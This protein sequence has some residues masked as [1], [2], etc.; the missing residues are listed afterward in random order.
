MNKHNSSLSLRL[1]AIFS[2]ILVLAFNTLAFADGAQNYQQKAGLSGKLVSTGSDTLANL[3]AYWVEDFQS[4]YPHVEFELHSEGSSTAPPALLNGISHIAPMSRLMSS[5]ELAQFQQKF[6]YPPTAVEVAIDAIAVFVHRD[7][8][9][10]AISVEQLAAIFSANSNC[11]GQQKISQWGQ[12]GLTDSWHSKPIEPYG[13]N[14]ESGSYSF[15]KQA[16][17]CNQDFATNM[18]NLPGSGSIV[19]A[20]SYNQHAIGFSGM[21]YKTSGVRTLPIVVNGSL[22]WPN[23]ENKAQWNYPLSRFLTLY[24]NKPPERPLPPLTQEFLLY[25]LS[26]NGQKTVELDGYVKVANSVI[27]QNLIKL[28]LSR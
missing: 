13:R 16:V 12:L 4:I 17:L 20:I 23:S 2:L 26:K 14:A 9:L 22:T 10:P 25:I 15:F 8:P 19:Q 11:H 28:S 18:Q 7:N 5:E 6:G 21:G 27:E 24:V 1:S 3:M